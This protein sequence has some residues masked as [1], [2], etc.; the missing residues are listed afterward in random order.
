MARYLVHEDGFM[1]VPILVIDDL[2]VRGY[3]ESLY[4]EVFAAPPSA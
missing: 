2:L 1:R 3:T 4:G